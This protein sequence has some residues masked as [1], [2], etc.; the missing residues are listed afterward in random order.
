VFP[1][2]SLK[3]FGSRL[4]SFEHT[5]INDYPDIWFLGV[6]GKKIQ[7]VPG[8]SQNCGYDDENGSYIKVSDPVVIIAVK[9]LVSVFVR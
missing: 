7:G 2:E 3:A 5:E 4:T 9:K 1:P 6:D 8:A